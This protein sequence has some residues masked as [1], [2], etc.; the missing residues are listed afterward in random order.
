LHLEK[1]SREIH[2]G[3][4]GYERKEKEKGKRRKKEREGKRI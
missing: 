1:A 3:E 2:D 4:C